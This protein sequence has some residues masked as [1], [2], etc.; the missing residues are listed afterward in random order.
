MNNSGNTLMGI[1][2]LITI[3]V[4]VIATF[5]LGCTEE[6]A[7]NGTGGNYTNNSSSHEYIYSDA[8]VEEVEIMILESF[9]VQVRAVA[10]GYLPDGCTEINENSTT[11]ERNGNTFYVNLRTMRPGDALCTEAIVPF[12]QTIS[13]DVYGLDK[14]VYTVNI[15]GIE[16][17][18]ELETD[19]I[20]PD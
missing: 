5:S 16:E 11:V 4:V 1:M 7:D 17:T 3:I 13:L 20:I 18:F 14:G 19:N 2:V 8:V 12:E 10:T 6:P 9:P 15:N